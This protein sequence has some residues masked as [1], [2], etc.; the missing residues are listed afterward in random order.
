MLK[1]LKKSSAKDEL[2]K[3]NQSLQEMEWCK[4]FP[5]P[6]KCVCYSQAFMVLHKK[7]SELEKD[8][9]NTKELAEIKSEIDKIFLS[10]DKNDKKRCF[11]CKICKA[12]FVFENYP[13]ILDSL[14]LE[15]EMS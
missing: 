11:G 6:Q 7:I 10:L 12:H 4:K 2:G 15:G 8:A 1:K 3:L 13:E 5:E 14:Y 9:E